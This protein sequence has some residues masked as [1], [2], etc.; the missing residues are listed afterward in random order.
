MDDNRHKLE[1]LRRFNWW[2]F[3][4]HLAQGVVVVLVSTNFKLPITTTY[5]TFNT[6][7]QSPSPTTTT[8]FHLPLAWLVAIFFFNSALAHLIIAT[9]YNQ[10]YNANLLQ[11]INKARWVEY[12]I[13]ATIML[14]AI[15]MLVGI[16]DLQTL[17]AI[18]ALG[19]LMNL[20]GLAM[21]T[22]NQGR[23][24][25]NWLAFKLGSLAGVVPWLLVAIS[26]WASAHFGSGQIPTFVYWIYASI[27]LAFNCFAVNMVLQYKKVGKWSDY[28][29]GERVYII[30]S[31]VAKSLLAWQIFFG[32]LRP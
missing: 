16:Y 8:L 26:F 2:M 7:S 5:L 17:V 15:A 3:I 25:T 18:F 21:E 4:F 31:L 20:Q 14:I 28:L 27:F 32:T 6:T 22:Y 13:S 1:K 30:L 12:S 11:G 10:T 19:I 24:T 29:Y 23:T 9:V